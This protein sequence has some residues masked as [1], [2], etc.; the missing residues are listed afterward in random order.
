MDNAQPTYRPLD[1]NVMS[2]SVLLVLALAAVFTVRPW[3][4]EQVT[5]GTDL[6]ESLAAAK[7]AGHP[8]FVEV[9]A[10]WCGPCRQMERDTFSDLGGRGSPC[11]P[12]PVRSDY[13]DKS[14][15]AL[16]IKW[17]AVALP[18]HVLLRED[19]SVK[20]IAY[21]FLPPEQLLEWLRRN[22]V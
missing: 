20:S 8:V 3:R 16:R 21:G 12:N 7:K 5:W 22:G 19:G 10:T 18:A 14:Q 13:D 4:T 11:R 17:G 1:R 15:Y 2:L 6:Q 9:Y